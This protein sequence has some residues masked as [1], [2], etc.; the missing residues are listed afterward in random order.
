MKLKAI[1]GFEGYY[2]MSETGDVYR[3]VG[4]TGRTLPSPKKV[5][6]HIRKDGYCLFHLCRDNAAK[7]FLAHR[8][9]WETLIGKIPH[10]KDINHIN[11]IRSDNRPENLEVCTRSENMIHK[12]K[13]L[14]YRQKG[15]GLKGENHGNALLTEDMV[16][17]IRSR[18]SA[19]ETQ[20]S[21]A[22]STGLHQTT[23][24]DVVRRKSWRHVA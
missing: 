16:R 19:G 18:W 24:S 12:F 13:V 15:N 17:D 20:K 7:G 4:N 5:K 8:L 6:Q 9:I 1:C 11:G 21:L 14:G 23:I 10:G 3:L 22:A 2:A